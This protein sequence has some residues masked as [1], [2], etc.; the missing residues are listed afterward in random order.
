MQTAAWRLTN[1][2]QNT[3]RQAL[4]RSRK[5]RRTASPSDLDVQIWAPPL[6]LPIHERVWPCVKTSHE[7][8]AFF[9]LLLLFQVTESEIMF[10]EHHNLSYIYTCDFCKKVG[11]TFVICIRRDL[12][13]QFCYGYISF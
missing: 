3:R 5:K 2:P 11:A 10:C 6:A 7:C 4:T 8:V 12:T 1:T 9:F 13:L